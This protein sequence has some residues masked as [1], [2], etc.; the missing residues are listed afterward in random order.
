MHKKTL[1]NIWIALVAIV[2]I[3]FG[4]FMLIAVPESNT[5][6]E[7]EQVEEMR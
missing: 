7:V 4:A 2:I 3:F 6:E 1:R 5:M